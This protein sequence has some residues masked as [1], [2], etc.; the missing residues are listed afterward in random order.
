MHDGSIGAR[1]TIRDLGRKRVRMS[2]DR[3]RVETAKDARNGRD[4]VDR[5]KEVVWGV[6]RKVW[7]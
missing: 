6:R 2:W 3:A 7:L 1:D 4:G 5:R